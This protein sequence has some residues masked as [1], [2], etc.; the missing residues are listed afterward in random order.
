M[1]DEGRCHY[2]RNW[3]TERNR[4]AYTQLHHPRRIPVFNDLRDTSRREEVKGEDPL[5]GQ[6][7]FSCVVSRCLK[8]TKELLVVIYNVYW[9]G[10][11]LGDTKPLTN[12]KIVSE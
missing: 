4:S 11:T 12:N 8:D 3:N 9:D 1:C 7:Y 5:V 10:E 6:V 2:S